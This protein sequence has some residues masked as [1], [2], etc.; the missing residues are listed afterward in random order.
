MVLLEGSVTMIEPGDVSTTVQAGE[1]FLVPQ[2]LLCQ[3]SQTHPVSKFFAIRSAP[4]GH[5]PPA[6]TAHIVVANSGAETLATSPAGTEL[7]LEAG[8]VL[9]ADPAIGYELARR[10]AMAP[11]RKTFVSRAHYLLWIEAGELTLSA[12]GVA[13]R[14]FGVG[15]AVLI[16]SGKPLEWQ[17]PPGLRLL[18]CRIQP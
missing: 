4:A 12:E 13:S 8:D 16:R 5:P 17:S 3:W 2:G 7:P 11:S 9:Y 6:R 18:A 15:A 1:A 10:A 14:S